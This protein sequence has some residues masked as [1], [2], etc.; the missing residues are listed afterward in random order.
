[1]K[2]APNPYH[3][4]DVLDFLRSLDDG[5]IPLFLFSPPY[6]LGNTTGGGMK[7]YAPKGHYDPAGG[8]RGRGGG[9]AWVNGKKLASGYDNHDDNMPHAEY[10]AWQNAILLECWRALS[11]AG[12]IFYNH[13]PRVL[14]GELITPLDYVPAELRAYVRQEIVWDRGSGFNWNE[15]FYKP[16]SERIVIIARPAFRLA[17][18]GASDVG[19]IWRIP[20]ELNTWHP[21]PFPLALARRVLETTMPALVC[22]PFAGSGTT[23]VAAKQLGIA[24]LLNDGSAGYAVRAQARI[25]ST[26][27]D[28][29]LP[30]YDTLPLLMEVD[31]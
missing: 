13:K 17:S 3:V 28:M 20:P 7:Q 15:A 9:S 31:A 25:T 19:D 22:D 26:T 1:M 6:N 27:V 16:T 29:F 14:A 23:G 8:M 10:V 2:H 24:Y 12:A 30:T 4:G 5:T 11:D 18:K 21:A